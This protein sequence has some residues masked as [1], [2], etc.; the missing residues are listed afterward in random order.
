MG[1]YTRC[2]GSWIAKIQT[3]EGPSQRAK[4]AIRRV[5]PATASCEFL[6]Q[7]RTACFWEVVLRHPSTTLTRE[8]VYLHRNTIMYTTRQPHAV[9][10][11]ARCL[12][13]RLVRQMNVITCWRSR[14]SHAVYLACMRLSIARQR[15]ARPVEINCTRY[16]ERNAPDSANFSNTIAAINST[17][18]MTAATI[19]RRELDCWRG[20]IGK[21]LASVAGLVLGLCA[22]I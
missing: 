6:H 2:I 11:C 1:R 4:P 14:K 19:Q 21:A 13:G 15:F 20:S 12:P 7:I 18:R 16:I 9:H 22:P 17:T 5:A 10:E 3:S 8:S